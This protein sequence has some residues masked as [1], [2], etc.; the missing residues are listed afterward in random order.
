MPVPFHLFISVDGSCGNSHL[1]NTISRSVSK[2]LLYQSETLDK[3]RGLAFA[4]TG[5]AAININGTIIHSDLDIPCR[6]KLMPL[7]DKDRAELRSSNCYN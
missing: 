6:G 4:P 7:S 1:M 2:L 3:P 5:V